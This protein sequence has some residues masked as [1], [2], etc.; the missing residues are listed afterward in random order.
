MNPKLD[1]SLPPPVPPPTTT[2]P[3]KP[4]KPKPQ[5]TF[6]ERVESVCLSQG[7][8]FAGGL[9][10]ALVFGFVLVF[11]WPQTREIRMVAAREELAIRERLS[12]EGS[13]LEPVDFATLSNQVAAAE[14]YLLDRKEDIVPPVGEFF[15]KIPRVEVH[16]ASVRLQLLKKLAETNTPPFQRIVSFLDRLGQL[17]NKVEVTSVTASGNRSGVGAA[18]I[19]LQFWARKPDE[20]P[21]QQ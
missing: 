2:P 13:S 3:S 19:D 18:Q 1:L 15:R 10:A 14:R 20:A 8:L 6:R 21:T 17:S 9:I 7:V 4:A 16:G 12:S 5:I 11:K